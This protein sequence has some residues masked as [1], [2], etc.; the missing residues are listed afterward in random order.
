MVFKDGIPQLQF[1]A[2]KRKDNGEWAIPGVGR[3]RLWAGSN[4]QGMVDAGDTVSATLKREFGEEAFDTLQLS[5]QEV[6]GLRNY[7]TLA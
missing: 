5:P 2:I 7:T 6:G 3:A 4:W 1:V